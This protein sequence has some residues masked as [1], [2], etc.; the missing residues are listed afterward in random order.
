MQ[1]SSLLIVSVF[2]GL[3]LV[4]CASQPSTP[5]R[6]AAATQPVSLLSNPSPVKTVMGVYS[7]PSLTPFLLS[8]STTRCPAI[9]VCP[10]GGYGSLVDTYEGVDVCR[11]WNEHGVAAFLLRYRIAPHRYPDALEDAQQAIR[12]VR[13]RA[14]EYGVDPERIGIIGFSAGG[15]L[16]ADTATEFHSAG[17]RADRPDFAVLAYPVISMMEPYGHTGSRDNLLG[18]G[19]SPELA[20]RLSLELRVTSKTPPCFL[21]QGRN[22]KIVDWHNAQMFYDACRAHHVPSELVLLNNGPH[23][24]GLR[25]P[26]KGAPPWTDACLAFLKS[27]HILP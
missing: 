6:T 14:A 20:R 17:H 4:G 21:V 8:P 18:P 3:A 26:E 11:W 5:S 9:I 23:G 15:H 16:A 27:N 10:G 13:S 2:V 25:T 22:D 1:S 12:V 24:F 7:I 19:Y